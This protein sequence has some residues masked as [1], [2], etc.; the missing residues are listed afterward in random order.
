[1]VR[2]FGRGAAR[3]DGQLQG[4]LS[5]RPGHRNY[6]CSRTRTRGTHGLGGSVSQFGDS[7]S[8]LLNIGKI[9]PAELLLLPPRHSHGLE[10]RG[11]GF[12]SWAAREGSSER[13]EPAQRRRAILPRAVRC[14]EERSLFLARSSRAEPSKTLLT[15]IEC[16]LISI[17]SQ[18]A[19]ASNL[20]LL[21]VIRVSKTASP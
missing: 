14:R 10:R 2:E 3:F 17:T 18:T 16:H 21:V 6:S 9:Q 15:L 13:M 7:L 12:S 4:G 5:R 11:S 19:T 20:L 1:M 8:G